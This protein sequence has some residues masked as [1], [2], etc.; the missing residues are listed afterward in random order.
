MNGLGIRN[1]VSS[2]P[3]PDE[4][5]NRL[6]PIGKRRLVVHANN[7]YAEALLHELAVY[8]LDRVLL[9]T[10]HLQLLAVRVLRSEIYRSVRYGSNLA[11][12]NEAI[13]TDLEVI[14][15]VRQAAEFF[16][17]H[18]LLSIVISA[19]EAYES[20]TTEFEVQNIRL[21]IEILVHVPLVQCNTHHPKSPL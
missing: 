15:L 14:L 21:L 18:T 10:V 16:D 20:L 7:G 2:I 6:L 11:E 4:A 13:R 12:V 8:L 5:N 1:L 9:A 19:M 3:A 17:S